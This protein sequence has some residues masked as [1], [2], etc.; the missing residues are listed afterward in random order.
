MDFATKYLN[1]TIQSIVITFLQTQ[2]G[3]FCVGRTNPSIQSRMEKPQVPYKK[4]R[5]MCPT[6]L[7]LDLW[8]LHTVLNIYSKWVKSDV[9]E[10][11]KINNDF[12]TKRHD[13]KE[14]MAT[15]SKFT[16]NI[17]V[18]TCPICLE[19][20]KTPKCL[21]CLHNFCETCLNSYIITAFKSE[22]KVRKSQFN[23]P[24]C[25]EQVTPPYPKVAHQEWAKQ[26][27]LNHLIVS[28]IDQNKLKSKQKLCDPCKSTDD[29]VTASVGVMIATKPFMCVN[30]HKKLKVS[31][32]HN[33]K[34]IDELEDAP[35][36]NS[37]QSCE[38]HKGKIVEA[39]CRDHNQSC[40]ATCVAIHHRKCDHVTT[41]MINV[42]E[43]PRISAANIP[44][45]TVLKE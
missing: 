39:F 25:R 14:I 41:T 2:L 6:K 17:D 30:A 33:L 20:F 32:D 23:C 10:S 19:E 1:I 28:L 12:Q 22:S 5:K 27:R 21:P 35:V 18:T 31:K 24:V 26:F 40:C 43:K 13:L 29:D 3:Q 42:I 34:N 16:K 37:V 11:N 15:S 44:N 45:L 4:S 36:I 7:R 9:H 8:R 38:N